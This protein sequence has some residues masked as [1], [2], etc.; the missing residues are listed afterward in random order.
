MTPAKIDT[1][2]TTVHSQCSQKGLSAVARWGY[3]SEFE[4]TVP[5]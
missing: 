3:A 4:K 5:H 1:I 2:I